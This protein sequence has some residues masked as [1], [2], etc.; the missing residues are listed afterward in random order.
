MQE[1]REFIK[2]FPR[3]NAYKIITPNKSIN[4]LK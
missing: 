2:G 3:G 4:K 1:F